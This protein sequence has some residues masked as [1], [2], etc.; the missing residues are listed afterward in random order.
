MNDLWQVVLLSLLPGAGNFAGGVIAEVWNPSPRLL[1]WSLHA[2]AGIVIAIVSVELLPSALDVLS[3]WSLATAFAA[4]GLLYIGFQAF[5]QR[6]QPREQ[7]EGRTGMWMIYIA[8]AVDLASDGL[9]LGAGSAV[10][11]S[12]AVVL[13]S[14]QIL[15]DVP[16][17]YASIATF[18]SNGVPRSKRLLLS[19]SFV[20][21]CTAGALLAGIGRIY[22]QHLSPSPCLLVFELAAQLKPTLI[23]Y[24]PIQT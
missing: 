16:E 10:S 14:G 20:S 17:G 1:N 3:G 19:A 9:A 21:F 13:A 24:R 11:T 8:V 2:A 7:G 4:G 18:R 22:R 23:Q 6:L 15:A 12:L 5:V